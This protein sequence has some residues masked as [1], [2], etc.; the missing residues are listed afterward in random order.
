MAVIRV[1]KLAD[2]EELVLA[3]DPRDAGAEPDP[4]DPRAGGFERRHRA[5]AE[6][7]PVKPRTARRRQT[8]PHPAA[9]RPR[10]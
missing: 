6:P 9:T 4:L 1:K 8:P 2:G 5:L 7:Q 3:D 10:K